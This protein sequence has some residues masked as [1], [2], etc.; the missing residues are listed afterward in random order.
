MQ[1][2]RLHSRDSRQLHVA[3]AWMSSLHSISSRRTP[4][5]PAALDLVRSPAAETFSAELA[6]CGLAV[7][8]G[9][10]LRASLPV[11]RFV[12]SGGCAG[13]VVR[14]CAPTSVCCCS[15][16]LLLLAAAA[17]WAR[18]FGRRRRR[19]ASRPADGYWVSY[20]TRR[21]RIVVFDR[22]WSND[23]E[24]RGQA[25][26]QAERHSSRVSAHAIASASVEGCA[27]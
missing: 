11:S 20:Y 10:A 17:R 19:S 22:R 14:L 24:S 9:A 27:R 26:T 21:G 3:P 4:S 23:E 25:V 6:A 5:P 15:V 13:G 2:M 8:A 16:L 12:R 18:S 7:A 1:W